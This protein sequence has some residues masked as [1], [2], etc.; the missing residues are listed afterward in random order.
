MEDNKKINDS[1]MMQ[2]ENIKKDIIQT[3]HKVLSEAN[4]ELIFMYFRIGKVI[5]ENQKYG[6]NFINTLSTSLKIDFPE[7]TGFSPRNLARRKEFY[8]VYGD[9]QNLPTALAKLPWSF[10]CLL[11]GKVDDL[12]ER[13]VEKLLWYNSDDNADADDF[14]IEDLLYHYTKKE[15]IA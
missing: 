3:R 13:N 2:I 6:S 12:K 5:S 8:D 9:I 15:S 1:F 14:N 7:A 11:I 10:N 4:K